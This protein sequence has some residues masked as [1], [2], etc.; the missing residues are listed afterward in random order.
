MSRFMDT[1]QSQALLIGAGKFPKDSGLPAA[2]M[3]K[4]NLES[5]IKILT[6]DKVIGLADNQVTLLED[7]DGNTQIKEQFASAAERKNFTLIVYYTGHLVLR[8]NQIY[9]ATFNSTLH[10]IHV[11]GI[12]LSELL[13]ILSESEQTQ[14][15]FILDGVYHK[16]SGNT[17]AEDAE[18]VASLFAK[19]E[20]QY[21]NTYLLSAPVVVAD[22][23]P[24]FTTQL[25]EI[26]LAGVPKEKGKLSLQDIYRTFADSAGKEKHSS[27]AI[28]GQK[29]AKS[30]V[31]FAYNH[32]FIR[33]TDLRKQAQKHFEKHD[34]ESALPLYREAA[35][36][37]PENENINHSVQFS[38]HFLLGNKLIE[39]KEYLEAKENFEK[40]RLFFD[41][42]VLSKKIYDC[43][44][45]LASQLYERAA[46]TEA[47]PH[48]EYLS[49]EF[50]HNVFYTRRLKVCKSEIRFAELID[51]G[52][53]AYFDDD[54]A[55]AHT[56]Y[57]AALEI[58]ADNLIV[59]RKEECEKFLAR[60]K[61]LRQKLKKEI[62]AEVL[63]RQRAVIDAKILEEKEKLKEEYLQ[64][65]TALKEQLRIREDAKK[66]ALS[67]KLEEIESNLWKRLSL[68]NNTE[69]YKFYMDFFPKGHY[70]DKAKR[71]IQELKDKAKT[72]EPATEKPAA[73]P[74]EKEPDTQ[75]FEEQKSSLRKEKE[76]AADLYAQLKALAGEDTPTPAETPTPESSTILD[77]IKEP[78]TKQTGREED[79]KAETKSPEKE[80]AAVPL[81]RLEDVDNAQVE[82]I[83][84]ADLINQEKGQQ[85]ETPSARLSASAAKTD[86]G[87][88]P[89]STAHRAEEAAKSEAET[90]QA[91]DSAAQAHP[92]AE[93]QESTPPQNID[94]SHEMDN[95]PSAANEEELWNYACKVNSI[96][97]YMRYINDTEE[98]THIA[99]AYTII[100]TLNREED[101]QA[102]NKVGTQ[103]NN[104]DKN[105]E[106]SFDQMSELAENAAE[107]EST[108]IETSTEAEIDTDFGFGAYPPKT[109]EQS[110]EIT[111]PE[112]TSLTAD[113]ANTPETLPHSPSESLGEEAL[114]ENALAQNS[115]EAY[116][117][118]IENT[119]AGDYITDAYYKINLLNNAAQDDTE[120]DKSEPQLPMSE[121]LEAEMSAID[122]AAHPPPDANAE[123]LGIENL[124]TYE[125][126]T[127]DPEKIEDKHQEPENIISDQH[128]FTPETTMP[129]FSEKPGVDI[130]EETLWQRAQ[131]ENTVG[132]YFNYMNKTVE[133]RYWDAAKDKISALKNSS[134]SKEVKDWEIAQETDTVEGYK[135]Y[136][137]K[138]P[139]GNYYAKAMFRLNHLTSNPN[140]NN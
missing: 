94:T 125:K 64:H 7:V 32:Q 97:G 91:A 123:E 78:D 128:S 54:Y 25:S 40:C 69:G 57:E 85:A 15:V 90:I 8:K 9:L 13:S 101:Q 50:K 41:L 96:E 113:A 118:Y 75:I 26:L 135:Q 10:Q 51:K 83:S 44:E 117:H 47:L 130:E 21:P 115:V 134:Q 62:E 119:Q 102:E 61:S 55:K 132:S 30:E 63:Q 52:D 38:T 79:K 126:Y 49:K 137:Q 45:K 93:K 14:K 16:A 82:R 20:T 48:Y 127:S 120:Q 106:F 105:V 100:G 77:E 116:M 67:G 92:A 1:S 56:L 66:N 89:E 23:A 60:E 76:A 109:D 104:T 138:Y 29:S 35:K 3:V 72:A 19:Y 86:K 36:L 131:A 42:P 17:S 31:S 107:P 58:N 110:T 136:I 139:L 124:T 70:F 73:M 140:I 95:F 59:R 39:E 24:S 99:D 68:W 6:H 27:A 122:E 53:K 22:S 80:E 71:R 4:P 34:Y 112:I 121:A 74:A 98:A 2:G 46:Y 108:E 43:I 65:Q 87:T 28:F 18:L 33:F 5:F 129:T 88:A 111:P 11:N 133:K 103:N 114:W 81:Q 84:L 37:F 12:G